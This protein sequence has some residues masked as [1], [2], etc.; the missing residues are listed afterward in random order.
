MNTLQPWSTSAV[1]LPDHADNPIHTDAG[2]QAAGFDR[3]LV[4]GTTVYAYMTHPIM[5]GW[6]LDWLAGGGGELRLR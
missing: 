4:A 2:A 5:D 6:G 1:N 3:A